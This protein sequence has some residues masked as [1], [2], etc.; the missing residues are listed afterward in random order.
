MRKNLLSL[1]AAS[2]VVLLLASCAG[3]HV[4][5]G[6]QAMALLAYS[7]AEGHFNKAL[8]HG[9]DR[10]ILLQAALAE[11]KQN[12][13]EQ[14]AAHYAQA[15][16]IAALTGNDAFEYGRLLMAMGR[17]GEAESLLKRAW[18][19]SPERKDVAMLIGACQGF[20][21]FYKDSSKYGA[22]MLHFT[23]LSSA[24]AATP[25]Q[26]GL[27]F[28]GQRDVAPASRDPWSGQSFADLY[29]I[30]IDASG[31]ATGQPVPL[32]GSVNG[33]FHE[34]PGVVC[35]DGRTLYFTRSNYYGGRK[36][37][38]DGNNISN[39]KLFRAS[40]QDNG[41]WGNIS[42]FAYNS[43]NYSVGHP[44]LSN[45]GSILYFTSDMPGGL[46]GKDLWYCTNLGTGWSA[47]VN[48]GPTINT[49]GD[50]MFPTVVGDAFYF[51]ST[52]HENMG[53][54]DIFETH[55]EGE[56][57]SEPRN[58]GYPV[59]STRDDFG[60]WLNG[61]GTS[62]F[63]SSTRSG[64]DWIH[65][66]EVR[67]PTFD[68]AGT[69]TNADDGSPVPHA[70]VTLHNLAD[71]M[72]L[73]DTADAH[74]N[75]RFPLGANR[76]YTIRSE[77]DGMLS[78]SIMVGTVGL[79]IS[80]TLRGDIRMHPM[81]PDK[82]IVVPNIYYDYDKWDIRPDAAKELDKL[83]HL[84][85]ENPG[86][87]FELGSHTD[88]RGGDLY[89]LVLS[90]AR[91]RSAVDYLIR[92]GVPAESLIARGYGE[93]MLVNGCRNGVACT[94]EEHQANRRT[95]FKIIAGLPAQASE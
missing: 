1:I 32:K 2:V 80:T 55:R 87:V 20:R 7:K 11:S 59:N 47:P 10:D 3:Y 9:P 62:G 40:L 88:S 21:T 66:I 37:L 71:L 36:L 42:E 70:L 76:A 94:E 16:Q 24:Y 29:T 95:E 41:E 63:L 69:I 56:F 72:T 23:G 83:A 39:L 52:G 19:S 22:R 33:P 27:L 79:G 65:A 77:A 86:I 84:F 13:V 18:D 81:V 49:S 51:S 17:Y 54:L 26:G 90:D 92:R 64:T 25:Y 38:K 14:A 50:E 78:Q 61:S 53:G 74:G 82:P 93:T 35:N 15:E 48:M 57:W 44:A 8:K 46:G 6:R 5:Q 43:D 89:N 31:D 85:L 45:D 60:L 34:G 4:R 91:A 68:L 58:M 75:F 28:T 73:R 12:K 67:P 30:T